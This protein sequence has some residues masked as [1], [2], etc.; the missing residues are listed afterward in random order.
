MYHILMSRNK[1]RNLIDDTSEKIVLKIEIEFF[2]NDRHRNS[3]KR[4]RKANSISL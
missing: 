2:D 3:I 4:V 1:T